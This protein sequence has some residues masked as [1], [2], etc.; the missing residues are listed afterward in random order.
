MVHKG[1]GQADKRDEFS[2]SFQNGG[3]SFQIQK[4]VLQILDLYIGLLSDV[5]REK[6]MH[7]NFP[8][9]IVGGQEQ[10][11]IFSKNSSV[12]VA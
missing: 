5:F 2:E 1:T 9:V 7:H 6:K 10:F 11:G 4:L 12:L 8:K 3:G